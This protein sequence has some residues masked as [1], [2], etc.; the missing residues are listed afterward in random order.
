MS[1]IYGH[2]KPKYM[3][4]IIDWDNIAKSVLPA[5][6][7]ISSAGVVA[8]TANAIGILPNSF[9]KT[10]YPKEAQVV[11]SGILYLPDI[12]SS[13]GAA[14]TDECKTALDQISFVKADGTIDTVAPASATEETAGVVLQAENQL[15]STATTIDGLKEDFNTLL[16]SLKA[17]G[18]MAEDPEPEPEPEPGT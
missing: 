4:V 13:F 9:G 2:V 12:E 15:D 11:V 5:G 7:P 1:I 10:T 18:I 16:A 17:A 3:P 8:N 6:T 14:L